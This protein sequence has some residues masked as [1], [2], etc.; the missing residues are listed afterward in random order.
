MARNLR[1]P[2]AWRA[3]QV[4]KKRKKDT[5]R[6][7]GSGATR[8]PRQGGFGAALEESPPG[9]GQ[10]V[11]VGGSKSP[12]PFVSHEVFVWD[13][14]RDPTL[15]A[16]EL[17]RRRQ[18]RL[19]PSEI[20]TATMTTDTAATSSSSVP[21][22]LRQTHSQQ[23]RLRV[24]SAMYGYQDVIL[25]LCSSWSTKVGKILNSSSCPIWACTNT[26]SGRKD[27]RDTS[28]S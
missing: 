9:S 6:V 18:R 21:T 23:R 11:Y 10:L 17:E 19:D 13:Q 26:T 7:S 4:C 15:R 5:A 22:L 27:G 20:A 12:G 24:E 3:P 1:A 8:L 2:R 16:P 28:P 25:K 14:F